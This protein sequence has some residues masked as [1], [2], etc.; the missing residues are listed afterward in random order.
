MEM[1]INSHS[2]QQMESSQIHKFNDNA[3]MTSKESS[4]ERC[5]M[6]TY[7]HTPLH[8]EPLRGAY[9]YTYSQFTPAAAKARQR[10][11]V[12]GQA[13]LDE[14]LP[15]LYLVFASRGEG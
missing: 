13:S 5:S 11:G 12:A 2:H 9:M 4:L 3:L 6:L 1:Q 10:G 8:P 7:T 15:S 14:P